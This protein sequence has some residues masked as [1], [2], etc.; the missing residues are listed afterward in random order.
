[1]ETYGRRLGRLQKQELAMQEAQQRVPDQQEESQGIEGKPLGNQERTPSKDMNPSLE[2]KSP[3]APR[4][5]GV[6]D[7]A[8]AQREQLIDDCGKTIYE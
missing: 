3:S 6:R 1:M 7:S 2:E 4:E 5:N 8:R